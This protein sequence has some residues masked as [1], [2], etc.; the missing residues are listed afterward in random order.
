MA[1]LDCRPNCC[2]PT[3][4][5]LY[6]DFGTCPFICEKCCDHEFMPFR[7]KAGEVIGARTVVYFTGND[8]VTD[9]DG[10]MG[11]YAEITGVAGAPAD[12][13]GISRWDIDNTLDDVGATSFLVHGTVFTCGIGY[14]GAK[15]SDLKKA[16]IYSKHVFA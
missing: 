3:Q 13:A 6:T 2:K 15:I 8:V 16:G 12:I 10:T 14:N 9:I 7:V 4:N 11:T 1:C 5:A